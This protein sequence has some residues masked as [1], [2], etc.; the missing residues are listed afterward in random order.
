MEK[1]KLSKRQEQ[2]VNTKNKIYKIAIMLMEKKGYKNI[3][4]EEISKAANVSVGAFYHYFKSKSDIF[5]EIYH[6]AD[7]YFQ[8]VVATGLEEKEVV[9]V[10]VDYFIY[11][12]RYN[13]L[14][15]IDTMKLLYNAENKWF[16][17]KGRCMQALLQ[18]I[19]EK[20]QK[21]NTIR[22]DITSEEITEYL[23]IAARGVVYDWC[24][25]DGGYDLQAAMESYM[26]RLIGIFSCKKDGSLGT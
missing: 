23:F 17:A 1:R 26:V 20:G 9:D 11:Y 5:F 8:S 4:V 21:K 3:T 6:Q 13:Q 24:L 12:A 10:V 19:L 7:D 22:Q 25:H 15:G 18:D 2:A 14:V 16:I